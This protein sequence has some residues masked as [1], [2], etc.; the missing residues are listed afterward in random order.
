MLP[1][2]QWSAAFNV[3]LVRKTHNQKNKDEMKLIIF[4]NQCKDQFQNFQE[5]G[6]ENRNEKTRTDSIKTSS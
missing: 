5:M 2:P 1:Q 3:N 4:P 6:G